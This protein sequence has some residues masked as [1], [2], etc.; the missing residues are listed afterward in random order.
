MKLILKKK[1]YQVSTIEEASKIFCDLRDKSG[2]G[3][4]KWPNGEIFDDNGNQTHYISYNGRVWVGKGYTMQGGDKNIS[5][6][7]PR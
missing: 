1:T 6:F 5:V 3:A 4:S 7:D 2:Q